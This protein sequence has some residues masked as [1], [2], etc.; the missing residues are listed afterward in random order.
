VATSIERLLAGQAEKLRLRWAYRVHGIEG[1]ARYLQRAPSEFIIPALRRYGAAIDHGTYAKGPLFLDNACTDLNSADDFRH[2]STGRNCY[3]GKCVTLD[4]AAPITLGDEVIL[5]AG[6]LILTH[7]DCGARRM[8]AFY[9]RR[10]GPVTIGDGAWIGAG[11]QI[12][13]GVEIGEC[14][15]VGAGAVV[16]RDVPSFT[17]VGGVPAVVLRTLDPAQI[18]RGEAVGWQPR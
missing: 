3:L 16:L 4:L 5:A 15:V 6:T 17:V 10:T 8:A 2:L 18:R 13:A 7:Q 14:A 1:V 9:P 11:A 12:L